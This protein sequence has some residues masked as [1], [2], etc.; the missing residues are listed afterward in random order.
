MYVFEV[1]KKDTFFEE[2]TNVRADNS[3]QKIPGTVATPTWRRYK[4][5]V[6][7]WRH[8]SNNCA[9]IPHVDNA[10]PVTRLVKD[11]TILYIDIELYKNH[12]PL[13]ASFGVS[14]LHTPTDWNPVHFFG[15]A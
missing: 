14:M 5:T 4:V 1:T 8:D 2:I 9:N 13:E 6:E 10:S 15:T 3:G 11:D 12:N 7:Q